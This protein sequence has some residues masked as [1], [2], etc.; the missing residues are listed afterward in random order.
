MSSS[1]QHRSPPATPPAE[2]TARAAT[3]RANARRSTGP[4]TA[5]G[6]AIVA[7][8]SIGHGIY[9]LSPVV[10]GLESATDWAA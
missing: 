6:K 9:A 10:E 2:A 3:N 1:D 8:N 7:R 4:K 5:A